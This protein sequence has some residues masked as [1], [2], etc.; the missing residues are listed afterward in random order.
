MIFIN[1]TLDFRLY[2]NN[3][4]KIDKNN[5]DYSKNN[6]KILFE[7]EKE[8]FNILLKDDYFEFEKKGN[9]NIF[10]ISNND[11]YVLLIDNNIKLQIKKEYTDIKKDNNKYIISYKIESD[12]EQTRIEIIL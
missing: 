2:K 6:D 11:A 1:K 8:L 9:D 7:L 12:E 10:F 5:I 3:I 4:L